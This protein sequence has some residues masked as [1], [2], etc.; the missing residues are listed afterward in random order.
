MM[1]ESE[2]LGER[3]LKAFFFAHSVIRIKIDPPPRLN[4]DDQYGA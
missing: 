4:A 2:F 1:T 3:F